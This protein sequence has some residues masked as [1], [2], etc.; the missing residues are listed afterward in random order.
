[1]YAALEAEK[2]A[3]VTFDTYEENVF[4]IEELKNE[5]CTIQMSET[6]TGKEK[7]DTPTVVKPGAVEGRARKGRLRKDRY[8]ALLL[9]HKYVYD[10]SIITEEGINYADVAG[11]IEKRTKPGKDEA[12]YVGPGVGR[13]RNAQCARQGNI[14]KAVKRGQKI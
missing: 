6:A 5:L 12:F 13:L 9:A 7:F 11:N 10:T 1:M 3:G 14:F 2:A 8:T 4:N